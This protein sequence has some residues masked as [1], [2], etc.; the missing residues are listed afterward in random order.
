MTPHRDLE[1]ENERFREEYGFEKQKGYTGRMGIPYW[2]S[3]AI[4]EGYGY[5]C[6]DEERNMIAKKP[7]SY[8]YSATQRKGDLRLSGNSK[9]HQV[10][11]RKR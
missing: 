9:A 3:K 11:K 5:I 7:S 8:C 10:G 4:K 1:R 6:S 2:E